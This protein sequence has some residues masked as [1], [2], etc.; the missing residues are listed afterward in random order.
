MDL[1]TID[2]GDAPAEVGDEVILFGVGPGTSLPVEDVAAA[3][4]TVAYE[5]L[6]RVGRRV[7]R[8]YVGD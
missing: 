6:V 2:V 7:P 5:I 3:A 4:G 8:V 1:V